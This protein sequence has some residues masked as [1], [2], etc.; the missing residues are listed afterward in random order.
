MCFIAQTEFHNTLSYEQDVMKE[1]LKRYNERLETNNGL[2]INLDNSIS[3]IR[4]IMETIESDLKELSNEA[5]KMHKNFEKYTNSY[6]RI[7]TLQL[8]GMREQD[9]LENLK[10][11]TEDPQ[12]ETTKM[13]QL[14][15]VLENLRECKICFSKI[16][17]AYT[18][19]NGHLLCDQ[20]K[21]KITK[22]PHCREKTITRSL[23]IEEILEKVNTE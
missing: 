22:C 20:C 16:T 13:I 1:V 12:M 10:K 15:S 5:K 9:M 21:A 3:S 4:T 18:C 19:K 6:L 23:V 2:L 11:Q 7:K 17:R 14:N 8:R